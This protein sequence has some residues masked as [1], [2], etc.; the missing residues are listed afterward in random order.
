MSLFS[1]VHNEDRAD[2][3]GEVLLV[4][5]AR[6]DHAVGGGDGAVLVADDGEF[7]VDFVLAVG[8]D[9]VEPILNCA[10]NRKGMSCG[11][12]II[13]GLSPIVTNELT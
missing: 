11:I 3:E 8:D 1:G 13:L 9:V 5:V 2:G 6:V 10:R 12:V 7:D 4:G